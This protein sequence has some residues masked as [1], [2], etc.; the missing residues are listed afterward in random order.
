MAS[1]K[2]AGVLWLV[3]HAKGAHTDVWVF[4]ESWEK[5]TLEA[6][7]V[8]NAA[9]GKVAADCIEKNRK[10]AVQNVCARCGRIYYGDL[11][12][13]AACKKTQETEELRNRQ[14]AAAYYKKHMA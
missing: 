5:A 3:G 7:K 11:P 12:L 10:R 2:T 13:C 14:Y 8:W 4:A 1:K 9:W 6:A